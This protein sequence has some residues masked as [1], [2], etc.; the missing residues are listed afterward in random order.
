MVESSR[1]ASSTR[2]SSYRAQEGKARTSTGTHDDTSRFPPKASSRDAPRDSHSDR[3][4]SRDDRKER[5]DRA[6]STTPT[7][8]AKSEPTLKKEPDP[9]VPASVENDNIIAGLALQRL[10]DEKPEID[11]MAN[12]L[13][14]L[15]ETLEYEQGEIQPELL[16]KIKTM[17]IRIKAKME[18]Q[19]NR[20]CWR[21]KETLEHATDLTLKR[22][23]IKENVPNI[24][25]KL[26]EATTRRVWR[27]NVNEHYDKMLKVINKIPALPQ[28]QERERQ[29]ASKYEEIQEQIESL[30]QEIF[31]QKS[32]LEGISQLLVKVA[33]SPSESA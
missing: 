20:A 13:M 33:T 27:K 8:E 22:A 21:F 25:R 15:Y 7:K 18:S 4:P 28:L 14:Q 26:D 23:C 30:K 3:Y 10:C 17:G 2:T 6:D 24:K 19:V 5:R 32:Q 16:N 31:A 11:T 29:L 1:R 9:V 12:A